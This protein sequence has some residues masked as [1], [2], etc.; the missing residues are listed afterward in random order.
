MPIRYLFVFAAYFA[1]K[2]KADKFVNEDYT[3]IKNKTFGKF[4]GAWCFAITAA[5][6]L[7]KMFSAPDTFQ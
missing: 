7:M 3:F 5:A 2:A 6:C 1:L 4:V